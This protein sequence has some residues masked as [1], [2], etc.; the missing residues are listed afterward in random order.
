MKYLN[1][2]GDISARNYDDWQKT[3]NISNSFIIGY[4]NL[5]NFHEAY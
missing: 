5:K 3:I 4:E 1:Q 2:G